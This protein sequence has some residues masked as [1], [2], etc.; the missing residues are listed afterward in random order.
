MYIYICIY[1]CIY[2]YTC[3]CKKIHHISIQLFEWNPFHST[4]SLQPCRQESMHV[5]WGTWAKDEA[6]ENPTGAVLHYYKLDL[7]EVIILLGTWFV[8]S[9]WSLTKLSVQVIIYSEITSYFNQND[10]A[11]TLSFSNDF[12]S[13][14]PHFQNI[15]NT[16][17]KQISKWRLPVSMSQHCVPC[18]YRTNQLS[19]SW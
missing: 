15:Q 2:I 16:K 5:F 9:V 6:K 12:T 11:E 14:S 4:S 3:V 18:G 13:C 7:V 17:Q 10:T 1:I 19:S 8:G